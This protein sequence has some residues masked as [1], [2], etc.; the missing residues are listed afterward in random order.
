MKP[1]RLLPAL[2]A[3]PFCL[4]LTPIEDEVSFHPKDGTSLSKKFDIEG[5]L[6]LDDMTLEV[7]G[8][9][10]SEMAMQDT[11][12]IEYSAFL[13]V[14]DEYVTVSGGKP[15]ELIR[16]FDDV[17]GAVKSG[18]ESSDFDTLA[19]IKSRKVKFKWNEEEK[20]YDVSYHEGEGDEDLLDQLAEDMDLRTLLPDGAVSEGDKWTVSGKQIYQALFSGMKLDEVDTSGEDEMAQLVIDQLMPQVEKLAESFELNCTY[21]GTREEGAARVGVIEVKLEGKPSL[22]LASMFEEIFAKLGEAQQVEIDATVEKATVGCELTGAGNL[23][24]NNADGHV[25]AFDLASDLKFTME[26]IVSID[27]QGQKVDVNM[28]MDM[29]GNVNWKVVTD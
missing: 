13:H 11:D 1:V 18:E 7:N 5:T 26:A 29:S 2:L 10:M 22:D 16:T 6:T 3:A 25:H 4:A 14:T 15:L 12:D 8:Q 20:D 23:L 17:G 28:A 9:D 27:A 24:W 21:K 19:D